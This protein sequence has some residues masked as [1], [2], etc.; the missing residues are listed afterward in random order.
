MIQRAKTSK[1]KKKMISLASLEVTMTNYQY[2]PAIRYETEVFCNPKKKKTIA[3]RFLTVFWMTSK[4]LYVISSLFCRATHT[5][6]ASI[7]KKNTKNKALRKPK[8]TSIKQ[9]TKEDVY[10]KKK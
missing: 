7:R 10:K 8:Q 5:R 1:K 3:A 4:K 6:S 2:Y 9:K